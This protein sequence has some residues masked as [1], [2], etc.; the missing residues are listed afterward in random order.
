MSLVWE[1]KLC[2]TFP[3]IVLSSNPYKNQLENFIFLIELSMEFLNIYGRGKSVGKGSHNWQLRIQSKPAVNG[4]SQEPQREPTITSYLHKSLV[5]ETHHGDEQ[6]SYYQQLICVVKDGHQSYFGLILG[7]ADARLWARIIPAL[8]NISN[9]CL[10]TNQ[11]NTP[12]ASTGFCLVFMLE[13]SLPIGIVK[14]LRLHS[15]DPKMSAAGSH[16]GALEQKTFQMLKVVID[17]I[18]FFSKPVYV[19]ATHQ[20]FH[21]SYRHRLREKP[22]LGVDVVSSRDLFVIKAIIHEPDIAA[23][24][25]SLQV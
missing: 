19:P 8:T 22:A 18:P 11:N 16:T 15:P 23:P 24:V 3:K 17:Q 7:I 10:G 4:Y 25:S 21:C 13:K 12:T 2:T 9:R 6:K 5:L 20:S 1:Q 14:I